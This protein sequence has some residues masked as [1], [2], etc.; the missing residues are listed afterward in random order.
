MKRK[1]FDLVF[2]HMVARVEF[3]NG[4][5]LPNVL[6]EGKRA[7]DSATFQGVAHR[8]CIGARTPTEDETSMNGLFELLGIDLGHGKHLLLPGHV[9]AGIHAPIVLEGDGI[10]TQNRIHT[11]K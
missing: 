3:R 6:G 10:G 9:L 8:V 7:Y 5:L 4:F 1:L 11:H 2:A